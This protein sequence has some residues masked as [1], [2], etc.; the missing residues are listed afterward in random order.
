MLSKVRI[1]N[2]LVDRQKKVTSLF[3]LFGT[4]GNGKTDYANLLRTAFLQKLPD[5]TPL[6]LRKFET[7]LQDS[8]FFNRCYRELESGIWRSILAR[9]CL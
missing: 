2:Q 7:T 9:A 1:P 4:K 3:E 6:R 8:L 5:N